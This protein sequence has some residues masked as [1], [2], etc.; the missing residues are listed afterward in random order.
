MHFLICDR[1]EKMRVFV[2]WSGGKDCNLAL[3]RALRMG[4]EVGCLLS[5]LDEGEL[6]L[7]GHNVSL[8]VLEHQALALGIPLVYG[9]ARWET[10]EEEFKRIARRLKMEGYGGAVFGDINIDGH[11]RWVERVCCEIGIKAF[12]PLWGESY[13][14]L[15]AEFFDNGF[16][17]IIVSAKAD[18]ISGEW[19][20]R[21]FSREFLA[22]L[23][24]K[25]VD[26]CGEGGEYHTL[27][28]YGPPFKRR[29]KIVE[30]EKT[31]RDSR[32]ALQ[33]SKIKLE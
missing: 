3:Y 30:A 23:K 16:E 1:A 20:G 6:R 7:R 29:L 2:S 13:E 22:Y 31:L 17:A 10:Y 18:L 19:V 33:I 5:M 4:L 15:L 21:P 28:V 9:R 24:H 8:E 26:L 27:V 12:E 14:N 32:W 25:G 11:R